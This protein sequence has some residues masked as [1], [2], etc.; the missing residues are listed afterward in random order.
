[1]QAGAP[2]D[3]KNDLMPGSWFEAEPIPRDLNC[4]GAE[5]HTFRGMSLI[6]PQ[7]RSTR[8]GLFLDPSI[9]L[10]RVKGYSPAPSQLGQ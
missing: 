5:D 10:G 8:A 4:F 9:A 1:M 6:T 2:E 7:P 3:R